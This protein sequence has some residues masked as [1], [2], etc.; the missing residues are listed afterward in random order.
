MNS[1]SRGLSPDR[2]I[3][4]C[5]VRTHQVTVGRRNR[6]YEAGA[7]FDVVNRFERELATTVRLQPF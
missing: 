3:Q 1:A 6:A 7:L 2:P 4:F 5:A